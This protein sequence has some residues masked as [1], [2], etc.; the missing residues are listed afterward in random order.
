MK[1]LF[2]SSACTPVVGLPR[3]ETVVDRSSIY[4]VTPLFV[5]MSVRYIVKP[6]VDSPADNPVATPVVVLP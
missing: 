3:G 2:D 4:R 5:V 1:P 6:L